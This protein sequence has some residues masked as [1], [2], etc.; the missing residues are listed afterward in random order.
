[1]LFSL[2][3]VIYKV[4]S[5]DQVRD[6]LGLSSDDLEIVLSVIYVTTNKALGEQTD[7]LLTIGLNTNELE[8]QQ[9]DILTEMRGLRGFLDAV[10]RTYPTA[11]LRAH[12]VIE[13]AKQGELL[14]DGGSVVI[15]AE[16]K[17]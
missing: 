7:T 14:L 4:H 3:N 10:E 13:K 15:L 16:T 8:V 2:N 6:V 11:L 12:Q 1:M 17:T 5:L 9:D